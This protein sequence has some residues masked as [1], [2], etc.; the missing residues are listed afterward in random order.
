MCSPGPVFS[1]NLNQKPSVMDLRD[2]LLSIYSIHRHSAD[3][4]PGRQTK[5]HLFS[6]Y[7]LCVCVCV[8]VSITKDWTSV[9]DFILDEVQRLL[10][11]KSPLPSIYST[12]YSQALSF[13]FPASPEE[14]QM[15]T[16][17]SMLHCFSGSAGG[18][19]LRNCCLC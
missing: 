4:R 3:L 14:E 2:H 18:W 10:S 16:G 12:H 5:F 19:A 7:S 1:K 11:A 6:P 8:C 17:W 9:S 15:L 13:S